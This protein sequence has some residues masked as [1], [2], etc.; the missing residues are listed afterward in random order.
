M[1]WMPIS[2]FI[3]SIRMRPK[4]TTRTTAQYTMYFDA[5]RNDFTTITSKTTSTNAATYGSPLGI[6]RNKDAQEFQNII[7]RV[8][9]V[10]HSSNR[11]GQII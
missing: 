11:P 8:I 4:K 9:A 6:Q 5:E 1:A 7:N 2:A 10:T 3:A